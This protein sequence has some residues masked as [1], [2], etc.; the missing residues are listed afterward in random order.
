MQIIF[1]TP[2]LML[3]E[4][5]IS[6]TGFIKELNS[7]PKVLKY[8][9]EPLIETNGQA[10]HV[11]TNI[12]LPQYKS[13]LGRWAIHTKNNNEC[14][15]WCGLKYLPES[16]ETD[17]GYRL[18]QSFWGKGYAT[19]AARHTLEYGFKMLHIKK[20]TGRAHIENTASIKI[21]EKIGMQFQK[22]EIVDACPVKT[23]T[24]NNPY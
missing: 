5:T 8:L 4:F 18:M 19:E 16:D 24:R 1:E 22:E 13:K 15:G 6:D 21:L 7:D 17:L 14:I 12:I 20:I 3:R 9:H 11:I 23:Y 10:L 2:R